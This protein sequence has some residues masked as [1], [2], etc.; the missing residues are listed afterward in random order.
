MYPRVTAGLP[1]ASGRARVRNRSLVI[2]GC[3]F[4]RQYH[5]GV[6]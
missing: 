3:E 4:R 1:P 5:N 6:D 2:V